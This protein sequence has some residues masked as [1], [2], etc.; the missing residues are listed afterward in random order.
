M[1]EKNESWKPM[2][3]AI[4]KPNEVFKLEV[5]V[6]NDTVWLTQLQMAELFQK[7]RTVITKHIKNI[8]HE[9][10]LEEKSNVQKMHFANSEKMFAVTRI[11][12]PELVSK[13]CE[14]I[15]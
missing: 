5:L 12:E 2:D 7:D 8:F 15:R 14:M 9:N 13:L 1:N 11:E 10:E 6:S 3:L 4:Y